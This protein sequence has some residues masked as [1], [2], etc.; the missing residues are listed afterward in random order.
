MTDKEAIAI[1]MNL[2]GKHP[3]T[4]EEQEAI[5]NAVGALSWTTL[6]QSRVKPRKTKEKED[7]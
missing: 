4:D 6:A 2:R 5:S 3:L 1:L 7:E